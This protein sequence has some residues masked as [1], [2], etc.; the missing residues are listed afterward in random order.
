MFI[1]E[2]FTF[3]IIIELLENNIKYIENISNW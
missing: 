2:L 3:L 1:I